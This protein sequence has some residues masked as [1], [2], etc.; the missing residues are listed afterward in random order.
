VV[1]VFVGRQR[2]MI[3]R[4][5]LCSDVSSVGDRVS[6]LVMWLISI[7]MFVFVS[8]VFCWVGC[9]VTWSLARRRRS[10]TLLRNVPTSL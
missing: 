4:S 2:T 7:A 9:V 5:G 3:S 1:E 8:G 6:M 10:V